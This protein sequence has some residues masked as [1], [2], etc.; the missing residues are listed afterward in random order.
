MLKLKANALFNGHYSFQ[1]II[2]IILVTISL[3]T[4]GH[5]KLPTDA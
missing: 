4:R 3:L 5:M 2:I 1:S